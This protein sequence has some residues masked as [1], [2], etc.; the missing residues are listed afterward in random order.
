MRLT[1]SMTTNRMLLNI[2][3]NANRM[4]SLFMQLSSGKVIQRPSDNPIVASRALRFRTNVTEVQQFQ[5]NVGQAISWMEISEEHLHSMTQILTT[6]RAELMVQAASS[7]YTFENRQTITRVLE[8]MFDQIHTELNGT[9]AGRYVFSG[10]RTDQPPI[11]THNNLTTTSPQNDVHYT[12]EQSFNRVDI[13]EGVPVFWRDPAGDLHTVASYEWLNRPD[14][15]EANWEN[16][17]TMT[18]TEA[19]V[20]IIRLPYHHTASRTM[21]T[22]DFLAPA[23]FVV[24]RVSL[25]D[26]TNPYI[27]TTP[28][29]INFIEE[30]GELVIHSDDLAA[31]E[32]AGVNI[33]YEIFGVYR[34]EL[35]P[36]IF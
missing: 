8:L 11:I 25:S 14:R 28:G 19:N 12:I 13:H 18:L 3:R 27:V 21:E 30:T 31:F 26:A 20:N 32:G 15:V 33:T 23:A 34:G 29:R 1:N 24:D 6:Q 16:S 4:D 7:T 36:R 35:N 5:R 22:P 2:S 10:F 17:A 9:Y